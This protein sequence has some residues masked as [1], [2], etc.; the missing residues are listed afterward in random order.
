MKKRSQKKAYCAPLCEVMQVNETTQLMQASFHG[1]HNPA[2]DGGTITLTDPTF[3][4]QHN[5]AEDGGTITLIDPL[6][7]S[8]HHSAEDGG[9]ISN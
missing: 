8:Q 5:P 2:E 3:E 7:H 4:G 6:F 1:Q 9:T